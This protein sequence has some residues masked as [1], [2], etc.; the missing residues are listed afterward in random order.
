MPSLKVATWNVEWMVNLFQPKSDIPWSSQNTNPDAT[1][2]GAQEAYQH[3]IRST[4][5]ARVIQ[6]INPDIMGI[7]EAPPTLDHL[8]NWVSEFLPGSGFLTVM[9]DPAFLSDGTQQLALLYREKDP[10]RGF[11]IKAKACHIHS[12]E[13]NPFNGE[14]IFDSDDDRIKEIYR[15]YRPPLEIE[16]KIDGTG[17]TTKVIVAHLKSKGIFDKMDIIH[18]EN[19]SMRDRRKLYAES[20]WIR[21]RVEEYLKDLHPVIVMGDFND[22][23]GTDYY[24]RK[25]GKSAAEI[26]MGT[27]WEPEKLLRNAI[28]EPKWGDFGWEPSTNRFQDKFTHDFV[29]ALIDHI[30]LSLDIKI[31]GAGFVWNPWQP[32]SKKVIESIGGAT[33]LDDFKKASDHYP[34]SVEVDIQDKTP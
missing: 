8:K 13:R 29:N 30:L 32:S 15:F 5:I 25:F 26:V 12:A 11:D 1:N 34:I 21:E 33:L 3:Y 19:E 20:S 28:G 27:M 14:Y 18:Y 23:A 7:C 16:V 2:Q 17:K 24:E 22:G 31:T 9:A 4:K 10:Q 6:T